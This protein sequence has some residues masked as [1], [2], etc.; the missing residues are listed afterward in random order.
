MMIVKPPRPPSLRSGSARSAAL[1]AGAVLAWGPL[2]PCRASAQPPLPGAN[3]VMPPRPA[4]EGERRI[5]APRREFPALPASL[6]PRRESLAGSAHLPVIMIDFSDRPATKTPEEV[7]A[8]FF[9]LGTRSVRDYYRETSYGQ[10]DI[11]GDVLGWFRSSRTNDWFAND[12]HG[13]DSSPSAR[14]EPYDRN[15]WGLLEE[16]VDL[17]DATVD[18]SQYDQDGDGIVD[19]LILMHQGRGGEDT[20]FAGDMWSHK[21]DLRLPLEPG[22]YPFAPL[23]LATD[24]GV[25]IGPYVLVPSVG[26]IGV[27][28]HEYGHILGLPDLYVTSGSTP[29]PVGFFCIMDAG[30][31]TLH[32]DSA[33]LRFGSLPVHF[34]GWSKY[35]LGWINPPAVTPSDAPARAAAPVA[36]P[37][38]AAGTA[39]SPGVLRV[40]EN[41]NGMDWSRL[42]TGS[43]RYFL[44]EN[45]QA[46]GFDAGLFSP[47]ALETRRG[48]GG[49]LVTFVEE[50]RDGND[51]DPATSLL[52]VIQ[53]DGETTVSGGIPS[54]GE[55]TDLWPR[56]G[57][58]PDRFDSTS[59]DPLPVA[60][61]GFAAELR[62]VLI[63][64]LHVEPGGEA[65]LEAVGFDLDEDPGQPPGAGARLQVYPNPSR[66]GS[67]IA[68]EL[69]EGASSRAQVRIYSLAGELV[70]RLDDT[71][72][73]DLATDRAAWNLRDEDGFAV[74]SGLYRYQILDGNVVQQGAVSV[75]R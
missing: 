49:I 31:W 66:A 44:F 18:F 8:R 74:S 24:D 26:E 73:V 57:F 11:T 58:D 60:H 61:R 51:A 64:N 5:A 19:A 25:R 6:A 47:S 22:N 14:A 29:S 39:E 59:V 17:A 3:C 72:E 30:A 67:V 13:L 1:V 2:L 50:S 45:R 32:P 62:Q 55:G 69:P 68:F 56:T 10:Y 41:P 70:R 46:I 15:A 52:Y 63:E 54:G 43:G 48:A 7:D 28:C 21:F 38:L 20:G 71:N 34:C 23:G 16:M 4:A 9:A 37:P 53:A 35:A 27:I 40:L 12:A 42:G 75:I 36:L 33:A 65:T